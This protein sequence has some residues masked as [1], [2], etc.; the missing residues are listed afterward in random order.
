MYALKNRV[1]LIGNLGQSPELR[2]TESGKSMSRFS[3]ATN[4]T[5]TNANGEKVV[6]TQWHN[7]VA[8]GKLAEITTSYLSK[9]SEVVIEGKLVHR[10]YI[11][12]EG[13]KRYVSEIQA[14]EI[15]FLNTQKQNI[16]QPDEAVD[17]L[18]D[19]SDVDTSSN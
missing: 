9:G 2:T 18:Q 15:L 10:N 8:W 13:I 12:K 14:T 16:N 1:Q 17:D 3:I 4:E 19:V 11:D 5:Y 7:V 6:E